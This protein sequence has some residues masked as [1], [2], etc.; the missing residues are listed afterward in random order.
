MFKNADTA[1]ASTT[2]GVSGGI[3]DPRAAGDFLLFPP[4]VAGPFNGFFLG[5]RNSGLPGQ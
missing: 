1:R 3:P 4:E 2:L 5:C